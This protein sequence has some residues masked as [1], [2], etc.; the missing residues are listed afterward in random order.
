MKDTGKLLFTHLRR[1]RNTCK[2]R[3]CPSAVNCRE[4]C[5]IRWNSHLLPLHTISSSTFFPL[6]SNPQTQYF[7]HQIL[8]QNHWSIKHRR[9]QHTFDVK[10][11]VL[12]IL[13]G[14]FFVFVMGFYVSYVELCHGKPRQLTA[15]DYLWKKF[16]NEKKAATANFSKKNFLFFCVILIHYGI[17]VYALVSC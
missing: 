9:Y 13:I 3:N 6:P 15:E 16:H 5:F 2:I 1:L 14:W 10:K 12:S 17:D 4:K 8:L 11:H 7:F